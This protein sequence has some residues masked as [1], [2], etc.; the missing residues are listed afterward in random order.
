MCLA[1]SVSVSDK[2]ISTPAPPTLVLVTKLMCW[3]ANLCHCLSMSIY[4][5]LLVF[6]SVSV[7]DKDIS[8]PAPPTLVLVTKLMWRP[9]KL[10]QEAGRQRVGHNATFCA[11]FFCTTRVVP[12]DFSE[13]LNEP[14]SLKQLIRASDS[15]LQS[16]ATILQGFVFSQVGL[17]RIFVR[18]KINELFS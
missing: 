8:T 13:K 3:T 10:C 6:L 11:D 16:R 15:R 9:A 18:K 1:M 5:C 14:F 12:D 2:D 7:S 17:Y 4:P